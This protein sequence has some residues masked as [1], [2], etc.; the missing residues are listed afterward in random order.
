MPV[1]SFEL[2]RPAGFGAAKFALIKSHF[3]KLEILARY[4]DQAHTEFLALRD[5]ALA[6]EAKTVVVLRTFLKNYLE[7]REKTLGPLN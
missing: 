3:E 2:V 4:K 7:Q 6:R 1:V 5:A